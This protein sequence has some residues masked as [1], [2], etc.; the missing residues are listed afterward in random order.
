MRPTSDNEAASV[1]YQRPLSSPGGH[2]KGAAD[3]N[4]RVGAIR[5]S[6]ASMRTASYSPHGRT[7]IRTRLSGRLS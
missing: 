6:A 1:A 4:S 7:A 2:A 5:E 3:P